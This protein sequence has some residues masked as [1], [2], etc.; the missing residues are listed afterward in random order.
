GGRCTTVRNH[1]IYVADPSRIAQVLTG[2]TD[3]D[4]VIG[5]E[6]IQ[7]GAISQGDVTAASGV[8]SE[9][10]STDGRVLDTGSVA[11]K[12]LVPDGRVVIAGGIAEER[13][14]SIGRVDI[15]SSIAQKRSSAR[16]RILV[17]GISKERSS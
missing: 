4:N 3:T 6:D 2:M 12:R 8:S 9:R 11:I 15:T 7:A 1:A 5:R 13:K 10:N 16:G 14:R 17:C